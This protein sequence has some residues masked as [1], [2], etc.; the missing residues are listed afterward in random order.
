MEILAR[1][2]PVIKEKIAEIK[3]IMGPNTN[4]NDLKAKGT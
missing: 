3:S 4:P 1:I 2:N